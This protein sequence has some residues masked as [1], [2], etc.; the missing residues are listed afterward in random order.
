[1]LLADAQA[2]SI[3]WHLAKAWP[4]LPVTFSLDRST[5]PPLLP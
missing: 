3:G 1:V 4:G 5:L 2:V